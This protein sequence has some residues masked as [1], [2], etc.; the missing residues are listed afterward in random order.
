MYTVYTVIY[1]A[2]R[3]LA[4]QYGLTKVNTPQQCTHNQFIVYTVYTVIYEA[5]RVLAS[6]SSVHMQQFIVY[7]VCQHTVQCTVVYT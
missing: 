6:H 3:V 4:S 5:S 1:Q 7:T 2:S